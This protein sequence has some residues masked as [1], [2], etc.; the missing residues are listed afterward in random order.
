MVIH[1][2]VQREAEALL[3]EVPAGQKCQDFG[4]RWG[5]L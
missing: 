1:A 5:R 2:L 3:Q 4:Y